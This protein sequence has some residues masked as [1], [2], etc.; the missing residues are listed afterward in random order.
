M[1]GFVV[2]NMGISSN[3][4]IL[5]FQ[6]SNETFW[7]GEQLAQNHHIHLISL[8]IEKVNKKLNLSYHEL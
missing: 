8:L 1:N 3:K 6:V 5:I 2:K 4:S 7:C